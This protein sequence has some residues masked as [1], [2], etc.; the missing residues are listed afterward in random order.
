MFKANKSVDSVTAK[1]AKMVEDLEAVA[2]AQCEIHAEAEARAAQARRDAEA[3][4]TE[5]ARAIG[6]KGKIQQLLA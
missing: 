4:W 5:R 2:A 1:L 3:A 6:V